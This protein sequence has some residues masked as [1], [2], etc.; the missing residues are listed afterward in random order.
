M[1]DWYIFKV[2]VGPTKIVPKIVELVLLH[3]TKDTIL[4]YFIPTTNH[5]RM[6]SLLGLSLFS[7]LLR[8][9]S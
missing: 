9:G 2:L 3:D 8:L 5:Y 1:T 6:M 7:T 4:W